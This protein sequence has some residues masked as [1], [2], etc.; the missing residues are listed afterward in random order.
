[1]AASNNGVSITEP[2]EV[3]AFCQ[4]VWARDKNTLAAVGSSGDFPGRGGGLAPV[5]SMAWWRERRR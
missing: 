4:A 5:T 1:M 3:S 2:A